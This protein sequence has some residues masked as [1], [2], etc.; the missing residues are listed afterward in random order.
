MR[1]FPRIGPT[2]LASLVSCALAASAAAAQ[3]P[4]EV[5]VVN[6]PDVQRVRGSVEVE[7]PISHA[8]FV[9]DEGEIVSPLSRE[10]AIR[11]NPVTTVETLGFTS[12]VVTLQGETK[13][14]V[15]EG[16]VGVV[17]VPEVRPVE[18][19][20]REDEVVL[21]PLEVRAKVGAETVYFNSQ[22]RREVGFPRYQVY[23]YN[24]AAKS[25]EANLYFYLTH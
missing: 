22:G 6:F 16:T 7:R 10:E 21:L 24:T 20:L 4:Q 8:V 1:Q 17:L 11:L 14:T 18:R 2:L 19:A 23:L 15:Q 9:R 3:R 13:G 25:V 12:V 5:E